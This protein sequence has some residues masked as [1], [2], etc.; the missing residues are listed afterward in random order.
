MHP[1]GY[2]IYQLIDNDNAPISTETIKLYNK[3]YKAEGEE[4]E[5]KEKEE[6]KEE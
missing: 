3:T 2:S 1:N 6:E 4:E 5:K